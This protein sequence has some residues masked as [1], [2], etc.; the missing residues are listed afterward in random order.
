MEQPESRRY[1]QNCC[2]KKLAFMDGPALTDTSLIRV[3]IFVAPS[4]LTLVIL[5]LKAISFSADATDSAELMKLLWSLL[6]ALNS[7]FSSFPKYLYFY[8]DFTPTRVLGKKKKSGTWIS[9][10]R[11]L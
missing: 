3:A 7:Y 6:M 9:A 8:S 5:L 1:F 10:S 2:T 11:P 4:P